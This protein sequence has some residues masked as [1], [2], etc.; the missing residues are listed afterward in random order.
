[1][2]IVFLFAFLIAVVQC[3]ET[4]T[5]DKEAA[6]VPSK[7]QEEARSCKNLGAYCSQDCNCCGTHTYCDCS[8]FG[9]CGC[10]EGEKK[11]CEYKQKYCGD[12]Q[13]DTTPC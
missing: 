3:T 9:G 4:L 10:V 6:L 13:Q 1:M 12:H 2:K 8:F 5:E 11:H 7:N